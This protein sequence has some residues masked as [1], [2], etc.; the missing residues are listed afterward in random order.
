[1]TNAITLISLHVL[2]GLLLMVIKDSKEI[3]LGGEGLEGLV[4]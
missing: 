3:H 1:M 2:I 4:V